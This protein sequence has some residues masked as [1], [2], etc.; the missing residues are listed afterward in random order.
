[1]TGVYANTFDAVLNIR[2]GF[3]VF[4]TVIEANWVVK[5]ADSLSSYHI[6]GEQGWGRGTCA[7]LEVWQSHYS[8]TVAV[9]H[10]LT[11]DCT[12]FTPPPTSTLP[13]HTCAEDDQRAI[14]AL[15]RDPNIRKRILKS[16]APAIYGND[17]AK[18]V[19]GRRGAALGATLSATSSS[20]IT[21]LSCMMLHPTAHFPSPTH[22]RP[23]RW[24]CLAGARRT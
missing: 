14:E 1:M 3:P 17:F 23:W 4:A 18:T 9:A 10:A 16:I 21:S 7:G 11:P 6:T 20:F 5:K 13:T 15:A 2:Q 24:P 8:G 22:R 19:R 12:A